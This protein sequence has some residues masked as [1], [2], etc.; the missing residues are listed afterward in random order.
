MNTTAPVIF[1]VDELWLLQSLVRHEMPQQ[2]MW[3]FPPASLDLNEQIAEVLLSCTDFELNEAALTLSHGDLLLLDYVIPQ[4]AA[5]VSGKN[6]GRAL[7]L[8]TYRARRALTE[9]DA[10]VTPTE[11]ESAEFGRLE[12]WKEAGMPKNPRRSRKLRKEL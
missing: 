9:P 8:K 5:N 4:A 12:R 3:K 2:E 1:S 11:D 6:I 7:L 10:I